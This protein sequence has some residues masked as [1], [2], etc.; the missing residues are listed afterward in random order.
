MKVGEEGMEVGGREFLN[1][2]T[3]CG[4]HLGREDEQRLLGRRLKCPESSREH[5]T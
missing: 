5:L 4:K 2:V 1:I 3:T